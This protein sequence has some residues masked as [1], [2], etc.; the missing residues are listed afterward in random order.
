MLV[1][2]QSISMLAGL[3]FVLAIRRR[4]LAGAM[5]LGAGALVVLPWQVWVAQHAALIPDQLSGKYGAYGAFVGEGLR[6]QGAMLFL[7]AAQRNGAAALKLAAGMFSLPLVPAALAILT[8]LPALA[9][10]GV[11]LARRAP[12]FLAAACSH[13]AAI[14][15]FPGETQ[16]YV[17]SSWPFIT[18]W[19]VAGFTELWQRSASLAPRLRSLVTAL[20]VFV[21]AGA[22]IRTGIGVYIGS[23]RNITAFGAEQ[24][25]P[26]VDWVRQNAPADAVIASDDETAVFLYTGRLAVPL[27]VPL[28]S[29]HPREGTANPAALELVLDRYDPDFVI[30]RWSTT[31]SDALR[32]TQGPRPSLRPVARL[33]A[34][35]VFARMR[36]SR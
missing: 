27:T 30:A 26:T 33:R 1:R 19:L 17:W 7:G 24:L 16:R 9:A 5:V 20:I 13:G 6:E 25:E 32:L 31:V 21:A 34:G 2:T 18:I 23:F 29:L 3:L 4:W 22:A 11:R 35:A 14:L 28:A 8:L 36:A 12:V 15:I 10:G